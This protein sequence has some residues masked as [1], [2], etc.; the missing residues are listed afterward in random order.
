MAVL[1]ARFKAQMVPLRLRE[2]AV[3]EEVVDSGDDHETRENEIHRVKARCPNN[4]AQAERGQANTEV[5]E[6]PSARRW[7]GRRG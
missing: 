7:L 1:L 5:H 6:E 2:A 4:G 3:H